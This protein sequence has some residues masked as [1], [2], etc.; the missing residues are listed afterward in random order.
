MTSPGI[1]HPLWLLAP[2]LLGVL[3]LA[4]PTVT[5]L[6]GS[7]SKTIAQKL[8]PFHSRGVAAINRLHR[9]IAVGLLWLLIS[10]ALAAITFGHT[11]GHQARNLHARVIV[12]DVADPTSTK[13]LA[14]QARVLLDQSHSVPTAIVAVTSRAFVV[15][16]FTTDH[17]HI[18]RYL[19]VLHEDVM[20]IEGQLP[21]RGIERAAELLSAND[22]RAGQI[23]L[24]TNSAPPIDALFSTAVVTA[25]S[26]IFLMLSAEL[27][28][29][30]NRYAS[31]VD[32]RTL[33]PTDI[34]PLSDDL[35][36]RRQRVLD[37]SGSLRQRRDLTPWLIMSALPLWLIVF[38]RREGV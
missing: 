30:W 8:Q 23:V 7:W 38:F 27:K 15:V 26:Q 12:L 9:L 11:Q 13:S 25:N 29:V 18:D 21:W 16:P 17:R 5:L 1:T 6:P 10:A 35:E 3:V 37:K 32:A 34:D 22:I 19:Q 36:H 4:S 2:L 31:Q 14:V 33:T 20:P 28:S 24:Y